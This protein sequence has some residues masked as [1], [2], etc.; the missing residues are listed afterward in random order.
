MVLHIFL[1]IICTTQVLLAIGSAGSYSRSDQNVFYTLFMDEEM[2]LEDPDVQR[3]M[4]VYN[5]D[6]LVEQVRDS[7]DNYFDMDDNDNFFEN[8]KLIAWSETPEEEKA[9]QVIMDVFFLPGYKINADSDVRFLF[10][11]DDYGFFDEEEQDREEL[12]NLI[13]NMSGFSLT[14]YLR[15]EVPVNTA[16]N[17]ECFDWEI[18]QQFDFSTRNHFILRLKMSK[19]Y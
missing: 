13:A 2:E 8:Y 11:E 16:K 7:F 9:V 3:V 5:M 10:T 17:I 14:Y 19:E 18:T 12:R 4:Y 6:G 15:N 1:I